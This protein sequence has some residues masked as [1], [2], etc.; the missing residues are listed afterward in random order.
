MALTA[1]DVRIALRDCFDPTLKLNVGALGLIESVEVTADPDAPGAGIPGV[2]QKKIVSIHLYRPT[3]DETSTAMLTELIRNRLFGFE[4]TGSVEIEL[5]D[6][7]SPNRLSDEARQ[8]LAS[9]LRPQQL[10]QI[11]LLQ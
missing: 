9:Q 3:E 4:E 10:V 1:E 2:P 6:G 11:K 8:Q 5:L 7:W